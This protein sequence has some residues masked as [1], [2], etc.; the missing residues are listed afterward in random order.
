MKTGIDIIAEERERQK[1]IERWS[2]AHDDSHTAGEIAQAAACYAA[3]AHQRRTTF[4]FSIQRSIP[5]T[6][7][8]D[9]EYWKPTP[10]D[11]IR[12]L[13]KAGALIAAEID[14]IQR[15]DGIEAKEE[16]KATF[17]FQYLMNNVSNWDAFCNDV[18]LDPWCVNEGKADS[19]DTLS[20]PLS[21]LMRHGILS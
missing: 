7:P 13:A 11:R 6:W 5:M 19:S 20:V 17:T 12:E 14:R 16:E 9:A 4:L 1:T 2:D 18:G 15:L 10:D 3:P 8:W 21:V